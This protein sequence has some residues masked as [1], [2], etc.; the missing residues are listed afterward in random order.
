MRSSRLPAS[1]PE[2]VVEPVLA[3][4]FSRTTKTRRPAIER[5][6]RRP[7]PSPCSPPPPYLRLFA[8]STQRV[9]LPLSSPMIGKPAGGAYLSVEN[10]LPVI[11]GPRLFPLSP[12]LSIFCHS[13]NALPRHN[14]RFSFAINAQLG[15]YY[16]PINRDTSVHSLTLATLH[17]PYT[18]PTRALKYAPRFERPSPPDGFARFTRVNCRAT[19]NRSLVNRR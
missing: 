16:L 6:V 7:L 17:C 15:T 1:F 3:T 11:G 13:T 4:Q 5:L 14:P 18:S 19:M 9:A 8:S 12:S 10:S 2:P